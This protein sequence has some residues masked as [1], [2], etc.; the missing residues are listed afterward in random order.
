MLRTTFCHIDY[1]DAALESI[2]QFLVNKKIIG[3]PPSECAKPQDQDGLPHHLWRG[4]CAS[5][6]PSNSRPA[7][8]FYKFASIASSSPTRFTAPCQP[9]KQRFLLVRTR[10]VLT[11]VPDAHHEPIPPTDRSRTAGGILWGESPL[12]IHPVI[13]SMT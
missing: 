6:E 1:A 13:P 9:P 11:H 12:S 2:R 4:D 8:K 5:C 10:H 3:S 7:P